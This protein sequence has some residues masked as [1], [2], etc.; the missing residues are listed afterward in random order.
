[1]TNDDVGITYYYSLSRFR[2]DHIIHFF[3]MKECII[4]S[5]P[6]LR[7]KLHNGQT[8]RLNQN[9]GEISVVMPKVEHN[10]IPKHLQ[11]YLCKHLIKD[12]TNIV[13]EYMQNLFY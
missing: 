5:Y 12:I 2:T 3:C 10:W 13:V 6:E 9:F 8:I 1:M 11:K 4:S 7:N